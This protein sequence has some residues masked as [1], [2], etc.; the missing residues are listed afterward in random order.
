MSRNKAARVTRALDHDAGAG[1][2]LW[3]HAAQTITCP[4]CREIAVQ[5]KCNWATG[6]SYQEWNGRLR[7][8]FVNCSKVVLGWEPRANFEEGI[9]QTIEYFRESPKR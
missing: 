3:V 8:G 5:E 6:A 7:A 2:W 1:T 9:T 4:V